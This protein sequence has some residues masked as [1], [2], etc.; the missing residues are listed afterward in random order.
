MAKFK[1]R[2]L[3]NSSKWHKRLGWTGGLALLLFA[4]SGMMHILMTWTGPQAASFYPPQAN[5]KAEYIAALPKILK[6]NSIEN[7]I[8]IKIVPAE[9]GAVLQVTQHNDEPRRYFDLASGKELNNYDEIQARWLARYYTGLS[10]VPIKSVSFKNEFDN[11]YPW[12]NRLLPVY[13]VEFDTPDHLTVLI[14]TELGALASLTNDWK[15]LVQA[16]FGV[17]HTWNWLDNYENARV[18][19]MMIL[20]TSLF[21]MAVTGIAMIFTIKSQKIKDKKR[22]W[23]RFISYV[24]WVPILLF[25]SSGSYHLLRYAYGDSHRGLQ[26]GDSI[27]FSGRLGANKNWLKLYEGVNLNGISVVEGADNQLLYRLSIPQGRPGQKIERIQ[28]F[29]GALIEKSALYFDA[30]NGKESAVGD[31]DMAVYYAQKHSSL[32]KEKITATTLVTNFGSMYDFRNKRLPVWQID[33]ATPHGDKFFIDPA[34][35]VVVD[36]IINVEKYEG[37]IFSNL[38]KWNFM[39]GIIGRKARDTLAVVVLF[40]ALGFM[41][42][43]YVM[44]FKSVKKRL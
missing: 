40:S 19:L 27:N 3:K 38:H 34:T 24:V 6:N 12:V 31:K 11:A 4:V 30:K 29:D 26:L 14:Y 9:N 32:D 33:F 22:K 43:G 17:L 8:M 37:Y 39:T 41:I 36:H 35:G 7:A 1:N 16:T 2:L 44:L 21:G 5:M 23:H 13:S 20:L 42:L 25:S 15:T 18:F 10:D 28:R